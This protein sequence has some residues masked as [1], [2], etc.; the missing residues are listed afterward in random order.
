MTIRLRHASQPARK[1]H[2][3]MLRGL[4]SGHVMAAAA[5]IPKIEASRTAQ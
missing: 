3:R 2:W 1:I 5:A 4:R